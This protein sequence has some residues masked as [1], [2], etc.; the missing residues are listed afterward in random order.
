MGDRTLNML[1]DA[2]KEAK[3][4][5]EKAKEQANNIIEEAEKGARKE[6]EDRLSQFNLRKSRVLGSSNT[7]A[8]EQAEKIK[9]DGIEVARGLDDRLRS[10]IPLAVDHVMQ[11]LLE[12]Q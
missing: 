11:L 12:E 5:V 4:L 2:E 9:S 1:V 7:K 3:T 10:K 8:Q 6:R